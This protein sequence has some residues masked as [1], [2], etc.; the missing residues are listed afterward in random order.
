MSE[1]SQHAPEL[2]AIHHAAVEIM[3]DAFFAF[4]RDHELVQV[5]GAAERLLRR[6]R[7][8]LIGR[9]VAALL[10]PELSD[11]V[12]DG[13]PR[14]LD[15]P[16]APGGDPVA[17]NI[18][19]TPDGVLLFLRDKSES[20]RLQ[21][22]LR[23][24]DDVLAL[25]E[26]MLGIG[27]WDIDPATN[28]VRGTPQFFRIIGLDPAS[29][30]V[31]LE[32]ARSL[33][34]PE[35]RQRVTDAYRDA[36]ADGADFVQTEYRIRRSDGAVRWLV[37]R[38]RVGRD[39]SGNVVRL[40]GVDI[41]ITDRKLAESA[42]RES[43]ERF[44]RVFE[45]SPLGKATVDHAFHFREVNPA[46]CEML[47]HSQEELVGSGFLDLLHPEDRAL[48]LAKGQALI[49][50]RV[51]QV[52]LEQRFVRKSGEVFWVRVNVGP[53]RDAQG[54]ILY[55]LGVIE[56]IDDRKRMTQ[57]LGESERRLR[58]LNERLEH[59]AEHRARQLAASRAQLQAFFSNSP[60]WMTLIR[61][62]FDG[63]FVYV[64][65][66]PASEAAYGLPRA[67]VAGHTVEEILGVEAAQVPLHHLRECVRTGEPQRYVAQR[68]MA[69]RTS[70]IDVMFVLV[71]ALTEA[72][73]RQII[74]I[75]RDITEREHLEAQLRQAQ[76]MEAIGQLT[77][78]V[79]HDFN[80]LLAVV[81]G[82]A[83]LAKRRPAG[84]LP[85]MMDNILR[86]GERGVALTRQLLSFSRRQNSE[87][88]VLDLSVEMPRIGEMLRT[89][90]RGNIQLRTSVAPDVGM[91][92][93]DPDELEIAL[94]NIAVNARDAM[95]D[96][97]R[98]DIDV[99]RVPA[100]KSGF[101]AEHVALELRDTG[102]GIPREV[103]AKVF[104]PFF[105]TKEVGVGTGLGLSQVYGFVQQS[106]GTVS[107]DSAPGKGTTVAICLPRTFKPLAQSDNAS[108]D[109]ASGSVGGLILLVEDN[110]DVASVT[111][112]MLR[113]L[114]CEVEV[115][116]RARKA[117]DRLA[118][119]GSPI[120]LLL[121][122]VVMPDGM[123]GLDLARAVRARQPDLPIVLISGYNDAVPPRG[124]GFRML[125]KPVPGAELRDAI[126][127]AMATRAPA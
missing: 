75:A 67:R 79:A 123:T 68:T 91:V 12:R 100:G 31:P 63:R 69:G 74:T 119:A 90:L 55:S 40:S 6:D 56:D 26:D 110:P 103:I 44:R 121:S 48:C 42:L 58:D 36:I 107:I 60:D 1:V 117:L 94:L 2:A 125:R 8:S 65:L 52:Q 96:G 32:T 120:D 57:A 105:T 53:I 45:Q 18:V 4:G 7:H 81:M 80:N 127:E 122:D 10:G 93:V 108:G 66:N 115:V 35:D 95:P 9:D 71:P 34:H 106:G 88:Q 97:G 11:A 24:R 87:P 99:R 17:A 111:A 102:M 54:N 114:G 51:P 50:G 70:T 19:P 30:V 27:V 47:G 92:E 43:E 84:S 101:A 13:R 98:F 113:A 15:T 41:D 5:N 22:T 109:L 49:E 116:D 16:I 76:K 73:E 104:D 62:T 61:A 20:T 3:D 78:G 37:G 14:R 89:S 28:M 33:P 23:Q 64:D 82:N 39:T 38:A 25:L 85:A 29:E 126:R 83:E 72:G 46:L 124:S 21:A 118:G 112:Q 77:G 86:A 59:E